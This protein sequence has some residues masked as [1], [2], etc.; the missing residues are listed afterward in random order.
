[1]LRADGHRRRRLGGLILVAARRRVS[2]R[3]V[4]LKGAE[5]AD[6]A[7]SREVA[8]MRVL[9]PDCPVQGTEQKDQTSL[10]HGEGGE[11]EVAGAVRERQLLV[12]RRKNCG[13]YQI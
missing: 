7:G 6:G 10:V 9:P 4:R 3:A 11:D 13:T 8:E 1:M 2:T 5:G 12:E